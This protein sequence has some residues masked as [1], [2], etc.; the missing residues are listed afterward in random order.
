MP[1]LR[2]K[3]EAD[4]AIRASQ[5][6]Q[7]GPMAGTPSSPYADP[8]FD[9]SFAPAVGEDRLA[10]LEEALAR[11]VRE[12]Y[13]R[14]VDT[15]DA[16]PS[17]SRSPSPA[18]TPAPP[19]SKPVLLAPVAI[20]ACLGAVAIGA[21]RLTTPP[22][23]GTSAQAAAI[24]RPATTAAT[25]SR[26]AADERRQIERTARD[27]ADLRHTVAQL[28]A[29]QTQLTRRMGELKAAKPDKRMP[30]RVSSPPAL[31]LAARK[32]AAL[33]PMPRPAPRRVS[34][35]SRPA[36]RPAPQIQSQARLA[37]L[38]L[39]PPMPVPQP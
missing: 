4:E 11:L 37:E 8:H 16:D 24:A 36:P 29:G 18:L 39:R 30:R 34:T 28:A 2:E 38:P 32:P 14:T 31:R 19:R 33:T 27:L 22:P 23:V 25:A 13:P 21:W 6:R 17:L 3:R 20:V 1:S 5:R 12:S 7:V 26:A 9:G 10:E 15:R 35:V